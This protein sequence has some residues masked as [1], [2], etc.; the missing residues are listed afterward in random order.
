MLENECKGTELFSGDRTERSVEECLRFDP[1]LHLFERHAKEDLI[2]AGHT[3]KRGDTVALLL[4]SAN[5]D[6]SVFQQADAFLP[7]RQKTAH[8]SFGAGIHFCVGAPLARLELARSLE[9][10]FE[11]LPDLQFASPPRYANKYH[12]H[13]LERL[14]VT[15]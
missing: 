7:D 15:A 6:A 10:L 13:G 1:P 2:F 3:F 5:R 8:Q 14:D 9:V 12:F 4:A 11:R